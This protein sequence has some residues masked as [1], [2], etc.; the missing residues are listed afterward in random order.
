MFIK[1]TKSNP[2]KSWNHSTARSRIKVQAAKKKTNN[3]SR[4]ALNT[5]EQHSLSIRKNIHITVFLNA[6]KKI[7]NHTFWEAIEIYYRFCADENLCLIQCIPIWSRGA[8]L[9]A[10]F[11]N[12]KHTRVYVLRN[13]VTSEVLN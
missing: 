7:I 5:G 11:T 10:I 12:A 2:L 4:V 3:N 1:M 13:T 6:G 8:C 9:G